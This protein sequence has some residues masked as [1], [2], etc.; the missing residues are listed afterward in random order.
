MKL[1]REGVGEKVRRELK[2]KLGEKEITEKRR[3]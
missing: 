2:G 3:K 1:E